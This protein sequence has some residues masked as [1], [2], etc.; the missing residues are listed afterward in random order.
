MFFNYAF[1][2]SS[3]ICMHTCM[4]MIGVVGKTNTLK[5]FQIIDGPTIF[6]RITTIATRIEHKLSIDTDKR[7]RKQKY[8]YEDK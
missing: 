8:S 2:I 7:K 3:W 6:R 5:I 4:T 1:D